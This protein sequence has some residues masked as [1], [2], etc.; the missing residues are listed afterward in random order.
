MGCRSGKKS[1][2]KDGLVWSWFLVNEQPIP[3]NMEFIC[4]PFLRHLLLFF[5]F[6]FFFF[7]CSGRTY[8]DLKTTGS[9]YR[10]E[11]HRCL[12]RF[13][14]CTRDDDA[15]AAIVILII[16]GVRQMIYDAHVV[17]AGRFRKYVLRLFFLI[18]FLSHGQHAVSRGG[19]GSRL[20]IFAR[21]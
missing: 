8:R 14:R 17:H 4:R 5:F 10:V 13:G 20:I 18:S 6:F 1:Q 11:V 2:L 12:S 16:R 19:P 9:F 7:V 3:R 21:L 15:I